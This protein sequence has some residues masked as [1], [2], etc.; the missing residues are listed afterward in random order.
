[1]QQ[2][3]SFPDRQSVRTWSPSGPSDLRNK[4]LLDAQLLAMFVKALLEKALREY[5][6]RGEGVSTA[7]RCSIA[8]P[9]D[10]RKQ[11]EKNENQD[12]CG[13]SNR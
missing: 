3:R 9:N 13:A 5:N 4:V 6:G 12:C 7:V 1:M 10:A 8:T 2:A 11:R